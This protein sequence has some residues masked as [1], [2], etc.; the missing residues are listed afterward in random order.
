MTVRTIDIL[1]AGLVSD[2]V[3]SSD[4]VALLTRLGARVHR[5]ADNADP[6]KRLVTQRS[7]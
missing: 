6:R 1:T 7:G 2:I 4:E 5:T 3:V